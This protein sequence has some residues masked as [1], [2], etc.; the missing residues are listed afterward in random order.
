MEP[1]RLRRIL[2]QLHAEL[3]GT[4]PVD[5]AARAQLRRLQDE[6]TD[7][8]SKETPPGALRQRLENSV[9]EFEASHPVVARRLAE[10]IDTL[11]LY[12]L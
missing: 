3:A 8:L 11:A 10:V 6:I 2:E 4:E 9:A 12:G 1:E 7:A 5:G